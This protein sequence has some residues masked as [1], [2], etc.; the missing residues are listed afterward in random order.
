MQI[1]DVNREQSWLLPPSLDEL[2][3]QD[4]P[5]RFVSAFVDELDTSGWGEM[6]ISLEEPLG[7]P[8]YGLQVLLKVWLF[9]LMIGKWLSRKLEGACQIPFLWKQG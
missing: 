2:L 9:G 3:S 6:G 1:R 7:V 8:V 5:A 4:H